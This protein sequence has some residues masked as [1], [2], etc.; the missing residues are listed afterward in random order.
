MILLIPFYETVQGV[1]YT[2]EKKASIDVEKYEKD[3]S[4]AIIIHLKHTLVLL[5]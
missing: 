4:L 2:L 5:I 1:R 3:G